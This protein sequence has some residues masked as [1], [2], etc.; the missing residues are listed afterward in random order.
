M[1]RIWRSLFG[2]R[3][4]AA[5]CEEHP[6]STPARALR[7]L[8]FAWVVL[9]LLGCAEF[10]AS[11]LPLARSLRPLIMIPAA[12]MVV[13]V[14]VSFMEVRKGPALIRAFAVAALFWLLI[15]LGLGSVDPV[16]RTVYPV[17]HAQVE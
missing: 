17:V 11:F 1:L 14:S 12:L 2:S 16:T 5:R 15:L 6:K 10:A 4:S 3:S 8:L 13:L 7:H 9:L